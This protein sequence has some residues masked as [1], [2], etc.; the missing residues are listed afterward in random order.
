MPQKATVELMLG[1]P[2]ACQPESPSISFFPD[3][4]HLATAY[5]PFQNI[6]CVLSPEEALQ[7]GTLFPELISPA[8]AW[9][10]GKKECVPLSPCSTFTPEEC[11]CGKMLQ[12]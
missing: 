4:V 11:D 7:A 2:A 8:P 1:V 6:G 9:R 10:N 5:V 12:M 3:H